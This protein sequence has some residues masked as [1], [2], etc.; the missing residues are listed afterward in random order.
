MGG[1]A[2]ATPIE[3]P[4]Q[5][6]EPPQ[7]SLLFVSPSLLR[8]AN[9]TISWTSVRQHLF[10]HPLI[11]G[12]AGTD[13]SDYNQTEYATLWALRSAPLPAV[14]HIIAGGVQRAV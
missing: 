9:G 12:I 3:Y 5:A 4:S 2:A 6:V 1:L 8:T 14:R 11:L 7:V 13:N 10:S